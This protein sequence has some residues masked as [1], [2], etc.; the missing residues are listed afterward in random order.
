M[1]EANEQGILMGSKLDSP[2]SEKGIELAKAKGDSLAGGKFTPDR[3]YTSQ[4]L[5]ARQTAETILDILGLTPS[6][7]ELSNLNERDF[8]IHD[9]QPYKSV[10]AAFEKYGE[11]PPTIEP[12]NNF[13]N[14][15]SQAWE[16][17]K[18][19]TTATTMVVTHSNPEMVLQCLAFYPETVERFWEL[20]DPS[21][22]EGFVYEF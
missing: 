5:R 1:A 16:Q 9:G 22:C 21:Y 4:L 7:I 20:G 12:V 2:L 11:N 3:V 19:E 14:R 13:V 6:L 17:I 15:V 18:N 8:G 10:L